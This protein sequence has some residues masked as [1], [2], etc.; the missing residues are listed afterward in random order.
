M[1]LVTAIPIFGTLAVFWVLGNGLRSPGHR[2]GRGRYHCP[3]FT[4]ANEKAQ[5]SQVA[6]RGRRTLKAWGQYSNGARSAP[7]FLSQSRHLRTVLFLSSA[8][9][10]SRGLNTVHVSPNQGLSIFG[11]F[12]FSTSGAL[13]ELGI[14]TEEQTEA[15]SS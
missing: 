9:P 3:Q 1:T 14:L 11:T 2:T 8:S 4:D 7:Q 5:R 12:F 13:W 15:L 10:A 6:R